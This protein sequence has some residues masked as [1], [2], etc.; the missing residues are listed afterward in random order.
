M[1]WLVAAL[2]VGL[3]FGLQEIFANFVSGLIILFER[4]VRVG[5]MVSIGDKTGHIKKIHIRA[6]VLEDFDRK[7]I[8]IPNKKLI[9]EQV[10]NWTLSDTSTRV[11]V[12]VGVA[13][14]SDPRE[15]EQILREAASRVP[16]LIQDPA[17]GVWFMGF[18]DSALN[19]HLR[20]FVADAEQRTDTISE[21]HYA[22]EYALREKGISIPFP[23]R[24]I[25]IR[26]I[27]GLP[28]GLF[29]ENKA[30]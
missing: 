6:T 27:Q 16:G 23:Q 2:G 28:A 26:D 18:G 8:I 1:Q 15:V 11:V 7:E 4:P 24:D 29:Q 22:I 25:H 9:T 21:L 14:G 10:T 17:P 19:F 12:D 30:T 20:A 3:G 5:D 13:Y